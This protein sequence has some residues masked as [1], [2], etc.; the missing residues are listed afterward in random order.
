MNHK[1]QSYLPDSTERHPMNRLDRQY[2]RIIGSERTKSV[3]LTVIVCILL[4]Y[5]IGSLFLYR[6]AIKMP[7][8][9]PMVIE[10]AP[11]GE[12]INVGDISKYSYGTLEV[13]E[14]SREW[15]VKEFVRKLRS[16]SSDPQV[17]YENISSLFS[18]ITTS[19][20]A[21]VK[22]DVRNPDVFALVG[23]KTVTVMFE[24]IIKAS[25]KTYQV[26]WIETTQGENSGKRHY[27]GLFTIELLEPSAKQAEKNPL[28]IYISAYDIAEIAKGETQ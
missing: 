1:T 2:D 3:V 18:M 9:V 22:Y 8:A 23:R 28:G 25:A 10:V 14:T 11:W 20:E 13:P 27:R 24:S 5:V 7:K 17:L 12:A 16:L 4:V 6:D 19:A 15:Q 21:K 26:D